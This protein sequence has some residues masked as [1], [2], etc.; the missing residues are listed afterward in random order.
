LARAKE[1]R[2]YMF[3]NIG[4]AIAFSGKLT[5]ETWRRRGGSGSRGGPSTQKT[6][7]AYTKAAWAS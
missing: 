4:M 7:D 1:D 2:I 5:F 6:A 3:N